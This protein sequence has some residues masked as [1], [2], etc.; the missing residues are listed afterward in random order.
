M[1]SIENEKAGAMT[2]ARADLAQKLRAKSLLG[3]QVIN[4]NGRIS[5]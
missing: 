2:A 1:A 3:L 4:H 5:S